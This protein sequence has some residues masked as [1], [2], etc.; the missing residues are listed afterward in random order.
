MFLLRSVLLWGS[1]ISCYLI[2]LLTCGCSFYLAFCLLTCGCS[3]GFR[4]FP[5]FSGVTRF[6]ARSRPEIHWPEVC[7]TG[8]CRLNIFQI[9]VLIWFRCSA[10]LKLTLKVLHERIEHILISCVNFAHLQNKYFTAPV[11]TGLCHKVL[12]KKIR[13]H[14]TNLLFS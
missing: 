1:F 2:F 3:A 13:I 7:T 6:S 5:T 8:N 14:P 4:V 11:L 9:S 10:Y 12:S